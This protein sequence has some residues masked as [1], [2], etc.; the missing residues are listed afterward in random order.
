MFDFL[1]LLVTLNLFSKPLFSIHSAYF[2]TVFPLFL[3]FIYVLGNVCLLNMWFGNI[4]HS[5]SFHFLNV[6]SCLEQVFSFICLF[7]DM[8]TL[9]SPGWYWTYYRVQAGLDLM[10]SS[11]LC[12]SS[13]RRMREHHHTQ[14]RVFSFDGRWFSLSFFLLWVLLSNSKNFFHA[15][16]PQNFLFP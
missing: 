7:S 8:V 16:G 11:Y 6:W 3:E 14:I 1:S 12:F 5:L 13:V 15:P 4:F 10:Q 2:P 9:C